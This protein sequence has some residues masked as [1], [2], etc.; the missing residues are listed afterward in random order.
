MTVLFVTSFSPAMYAASAQPFLESF[1]AR[2]RGASIVV[3]YEGEMPPLLRSEKIIPHALET[4]KF[5]QDWLEANRDVIPAAL[6]GDWAGCACS[7]RHPR[8]PE[9]LAHELFCPGG[10]FNYNASLFFRKVATLRTALA[11]ARRKKLDTLVWMDCDCVIHQALSRLFLRSLLN[12]S[13]CAVL[14]GDRRVIEACV[15]IFNLKGKGG[16]VLDAVF[17]DYIS[18]DFRKQK[19]WDDGNL[20]TR[21]LERRQDFVKRDLVANNGGDSKTIPL[22]PLAIYVEHAKGRHKKLGIFGG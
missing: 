16:H 9:K 12:S 1:L 6:G 8:F 13:D 15:M 5:L 22:S 11:R 4:D 17:E 18:G 21:V 20:F 7:R 10:Y 2:Q 14:Q 3:G 19:R